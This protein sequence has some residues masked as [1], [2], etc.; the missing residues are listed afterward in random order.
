MIKPVLLFLAGA[1]AA[2]ASGVS[3]IFL[4]RSSARGLA[5]DVDELLQHLVCGRDR[6]RVGREGALV[7]DQ[8][9]ELL[10]EVHVGR[11]ERGCAD[12]GATAGAR[13]A[14]RRRAALARLDP[15]VL[16]CAAEAVVGAELGHRQ[17]PDRDLLT[18]GV[19]ALHEA[20]A[21]DRQTRELTRCVAI[22]RLARH[23]GGRRELRGAV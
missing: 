15:Q 10:A 3:D 16:P 6:A 5:L 14:E 23:G 19:Q 13:R 7:L 21:V 17:L 22:L 11:L 4:S 2:A 1:A 9:D 12:R 20:R 18:V 8:T